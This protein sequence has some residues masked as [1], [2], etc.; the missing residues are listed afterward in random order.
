VSSVVDKEERRLASRER[1]AVMRGHSSFSRDASRERI[2]PGEGSYKAVFP[3]QSVFEVA[4]C[5]A[6]QSLEDPARR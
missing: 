1:A 4:D 3:E 6:Y 5:F 2:Y